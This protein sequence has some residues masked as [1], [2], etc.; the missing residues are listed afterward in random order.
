MCPWEDASTASHISARTVSYVHRVSFLCLPPTQLSCIPNL[1]EWLQH[2]SVAQRQVLG[3][4]LDFLTISPH[5][6]LRLP[7]ANI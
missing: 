6:M 7:P 4:I 5:V 3:L 2:P 1:S